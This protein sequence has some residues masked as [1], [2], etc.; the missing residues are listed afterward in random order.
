MLRRLR[1]RL[2]R[3]HPGGCERSRQDRDGMPEH[4]RCTETQRPARGRVRRQVCGSQSYCAPLA[5]AAGR[6]LSL[7]G[8][9]AR[10][11]PSLV[12]DPSVVGG[13]ASVV[14]P[15]ETGISKGS[16]TGSPSR[17][18]SR[19]GFRLVR[20]ACTQRV[21][22][23]T[24]RSYG[25][26]VAGGRTCRDPCLN[27]WSNLSRPVPQ[28][29]VGPVGTR[30][31]TG[32]RTCRDPCLN[33]WS[34]PSGP[35]SDRRSEP[36]PVVE[37]VGTRVCGVGELRRPSRQDSVCMTSSPDAVHPGQ[38]NR[39]MHNRQRLV[40]A[41]AAAIGILQPRRRFSSAA[42]PRAQGRLRVVRTCRLQIR[43]AARRSR[44]AHAIQQRASVHLGKGR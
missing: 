3:R 5:V 34:G 22:E 13:G 26:R 31:S 39:S 19:C 9:R 10:R 7:T 11:D 25:Y 18:S 27:R 23:R 6:D 42:A 41:A 17:H 32:G 20:P 37:S 38:E 29:V 43:A 28:P 4:G 44:L 35:E 15:V 33:R 12:G 1:S 40:T 30:A 36:P 14:G 2:Q 21:H 8:G 16:I 24:A